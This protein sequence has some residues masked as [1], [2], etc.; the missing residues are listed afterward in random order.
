MARNFSLRNLYIFVVANKKTGGGHLSRQ[1]NI[2]KNL[3]VPC[4]IITL[5]NSIIGE[6]TIDLVDDIIL[7]KA[8]DYKQI[9]RVVERDSVLIFDPPY[10]EKELNTYE[11]AKEFFFLDRLRKKNIRVIYFTDEFLARTR[12][13]S[14]VVNGY[15][16]SEELEEIYSRDGAD[17]IVGIDAFVF[18]YDRDMVVSNPDESRKQVF[19]NFGYFDQH[20]L[21]SGIGEV[22][23]LLSDSGCVV[24]FVGQE[25]SLTFAEEIM[26]LNIH[27]NLKQKEFLDLLAK[28]DLAI[29]SAGNVNYERMLLGV[30][31]I[32]IPQ[33]GRQAVYSMVADKLGVSIHLDS[34][35]YLKSTVT[36]WI[37]GDFSRIS[38]QCF[39]LGQ[40]SS[41]N[42]HPDNLLVDK[43]KS[44]IFG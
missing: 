6:E 10:Y 15:L 2:I 43:I 27:A 32:S 39:R 1:N 19:V 29:V 21:A 37:E 35:S 7:I 38:K 3:R 8:F 24:N 13:V 17:T 36:E 20:L 5:E 42:E 23:K 11:S 33:F 22:I 31:G 12:P 41:P 34:L 26:N 9:E 4:K 25:G 14:L 40:L 28:A 44:C 16:E 18:S 30:P